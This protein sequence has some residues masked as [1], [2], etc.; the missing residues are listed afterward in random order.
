MS[1][2]YIKNHI[3]QLEA[4]IVAGEKLR[5]E[6]RRKSEGKDAIIR[7]QAIE[8]K[9][10]TQLNEMLR[11]RRNRAIRRLNVARNEL[12]GVRTKLDRLLNQQ[13][14][15]EAFFTAVKTAAIELGVWEQLRDRA[16]QRE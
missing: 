4:M 3:E 2:Q 6:M 12:T 8:L 9:N 7:R 16:L 14:G 10:K 11:E 15:N 1:V 5:D 13:D